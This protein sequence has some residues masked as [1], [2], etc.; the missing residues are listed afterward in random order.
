MR[1][2]GRSIS[3]RFSTRLSVSVLTAVVAAA[4][5]TPLASAAVPAFPD[6][7][8]GVNNFDYATCER[9]DF[10]AQ[11]QDSISQSAT[12]LWYGVWT[13]A[14]LLIVLLITPMFVDAFR[15]WR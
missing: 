7:C 11:T 13:L 9:L 5:V 15:F 6:A 12:L 8:G 10:I 2:N 3:A 4:L 1:G 14:G